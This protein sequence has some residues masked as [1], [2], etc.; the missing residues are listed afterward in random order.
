M[1]VLWFEFVLT[2]R[3][4]FRRRTQNGL[5]LV[6]FALSVTL[7]LLSWS[8]FRTV[9]LSNPDFDPK[10]EYLVLAHANKMWTNAGQLTLEELDAYAKAQTVFEDV[11]PMAFYLSIFVRT[12]AG[13]ERLLGGYLSS[14]VLQ[15]TGAKPLL[16]TL[17]TAA[18]DKD[19][20]P[21]RVLLSERVWRDSYGSDPAIVGKPI[22]L[23]GDPGTIIGV[24]PASYRF[25]NDQQVWMS[26]GFVGDGY[27]K[28]YAMRTALV[29]LKPGITRAR[30]ERD[31]QA[32]LSTLPPQ[33]AAIRHGDRPVLVPYREFFLWS[34]VQVSSLILFALAG[35]FLA[36]S[37]A[38][39]ANLMVIDFLGRRAELA[40]GLALG[41]PR[42][43]AMRQVGWHVVLIA[44]LAA[45]I[46]LAVLPLA[47]PLLFERVRVINGPYWMNYAFSWND[48]K[49]AALFAGVAAVATAITPIVYLGLVQPD[50]LIR[51]HATSSRGSGRA[52]WR[53]TL[54]AGQIAL[55]TTLGVCSA[56]LVRSNRNVGEDRW[57]FNGAEIFEAR[58]STLSLSYP[59]H[60]WRQGRYATLKKCLDE[61]RRRPE[62]EEAALVDNPT[63]YSNGPY[64]SYATD[65]KALAGDAKQGEAFA[66]TVT[67]R[68]FAVL[69]VPFVAGE[70]FRAEVPA[71]APDEAIINASLAQKLWPGQDPLQ[72]ALYVR[73]KDM[74]PTDPPVRL[75]VRGVVRDFQPNGPRAKTND[76][77]FQ[78]YRPADGAGATLVLYARDHGG[79]PT[80]RSINDATHRAEPRVAVYFASTIKRQIDLMLN[81]V[82]MT[83]DLTTVFALAAVLLGAIGVYSLTVTQ[84]LQSAREFGIRMALG[85][86][87]RRLWRDFT[88]GH[89]LTVLIGVVLG[90]VGASQAVRVLG[91]MLVGVDPHSLLTYVAVAVGILFVATLACLP[92]LRRLKRINPSECLRSL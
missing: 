92:S 31:L 5:L 4:L 24:M 81:S 66:A 39:A 36:V 48:V 50:K 67:D 22:E 87:P 30:A 47:G 29:K 76:A 89:L 20:A 63:G 52:W 15:L 35:L 16:G 85:A 70:D 27:S 71:G 80:F 91:A 72:R 3:R 75:V 45:L 64:C 78:G 37:C 13:D 69:R 73:Y 82:R 51:E 49:M 25:P 56:L 68:Y 40:T 65:P 77:I 32:I 90:V 19:G 44:L 23:S 8:L 34:D 41:I 46:A 14:S 79:M 74:K 2:L 6:T 60:Q 59:D 12:P 86:E 28:D 9:H 21:Q 61:I 38:N 26:Y 57:G 58:L 42:R 53:R 43:A 55:L 88:R 83:A 1:S 84:V 33:T 17:F 7:S 18:D 54:L 11:R 62:T 10:G